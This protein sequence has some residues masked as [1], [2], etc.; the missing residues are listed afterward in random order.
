M[1][2]KR[3][4]LRLRRHNVFMKW[5][6]IAVVSIF[7]LLL[8]AVFVIG[9]LNE[10]QTFE[11]Q[12]DSDTYTK[13]F[14]S[15]DECRYIFP[16]GSCV[17][18]DEYCNLNSY[19]Y[20]VLELEPHTD[21]C[22]KGTIV[23]NA[24]V[25]NSEPRIVQQQKAGE[26][27]F[28]VSEGDS[29]RLNPD[30]YDP[31]PDVGPAGKL[32]WTFFKP[33]DTSGIWRTV[34]GDAGRT[35]SKVRLSDGELFDEEEF[36]VDVAVSNHPPTLSG[37]RDVS[38]SEGDKVT[39]T[40]RCTDPDGDK[41]TI[42]ISGF[43]TAGQKELD[44]DDAGKHEVTV[45]C[46]DPD[47]EKDVEKLNVVVAD[48]N[49]PP[50]LDVPD[51][52]TVDEGKIAEIKAETSDPDGD[53]VTV[54]FDDPFSQV[55]TWRTVKGDAGSY[56][57]TVRATDGSK[58]VTKTVRVVVNKV[59]SKPSVS[60]LRDV[61]V[62]EGDKIVLRPR[63]RDSDGDKVSIK[64]SGW[65]TSDTKQTGYDDAGE[66]DVA[67]TVSDGTEEVKNT[68]HV[69]VLNRNRAPVITDLK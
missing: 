40:P 10:P 56:R 54:I 50:T 8:L 24:P 31:D 13:Y 41:V 62:Y 49:R 21:Y 44:Y 57:V 67:L 25:E 53:K 60:G 38:A 35:V 4:Y 9:E 29:V 1:R 69:V 15:R 14:F 52:V 3:T 45:T 22:F 68:V 65:M 64:Y 46:E 48:V 47:G 26:C 39:I 51:T 63:I 16:E 28:E 7:A 66:Y 6:F 33:F 18:E 59:N 17:V 34:K 2:I 32:I 37:L 12:K 36:C 61:T 5:K 43:M 11:K 58:Q 23:Y 42:K 30:G 55:G 27:L 19:D 20:K